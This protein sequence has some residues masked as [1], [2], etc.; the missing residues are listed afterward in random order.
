MSYY[1][2][3][4]SGAPQSAEALAGELNKCVELQETMKAV[5]A[6]WRKAGTCVGAPG[7]TEAQ[8]KRLDEKIATT[9][10]SWEK[11]PFST[12]DLTN[13]NSKIK[14][15]ESKV[16]EAGKGF[17]GWEFHGGRAEANTEI[18]R[19]Q[20]FFDERPGEKQRAVLKANG[21]KWA[22]SQDAWQR[23]LTDNAIYSAGRI[24][25]IEPSDGR[26]VRDHQPKAPARDD[27]A[28]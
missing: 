6:Y 20:L 14:S 5:N 12:Y 8:A 19:L 22:P 18:N 7:I 28:R 4:P 23:Q 16:K 11:Q 26:S 10:Y 13:N 21:F 2:S 3:K 25:F 17:E 24:D 27:G 15:L 9:R 1:N